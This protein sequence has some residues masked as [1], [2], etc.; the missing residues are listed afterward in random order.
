MIG[1]DGEY[2][3]CFVQQQ[4]SCGN[5]SENMAE[6]FRQG[7]KVIEQYVESTVRKVHF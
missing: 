6:A 4:N 3:P 5:V 7:D 2:Y 1:P